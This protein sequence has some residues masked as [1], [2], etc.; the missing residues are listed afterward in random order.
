LIEQRAPPALRFQSVRP[1]FEP[2]AV[3]VYVLAT[4]G[5]QFLT[6]F[7]L[8]IFDDHYIGLDLPVGI[9]GSLFVA[10]RAVVEL[11]VLV[12]RASS[13]TPKTQSFPRSRTGARAFAGKTDVGNRTTDGCLIS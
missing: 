4:F 13:P 8:R 1:G 12:Q 10:P 5:M 11:D 9:E 6:G 3:V 2:G 7:S